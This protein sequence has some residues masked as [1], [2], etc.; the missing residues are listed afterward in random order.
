MTFGYSRDD[1]EG[2]FLTH[3]VESNLLPDNPFQVLDRDGV[4]RLIEWAVE[5]GK[6]VKPQLKTSICGEHG[7]DKQ[8]IFFC[9][10]VGLDYVSCS[11][12][13][14]P[15]ARIAAA[16]AQLALGKAQKNEETGLIPER[17]A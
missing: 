10:A 14:V 8:S 9:H 13:R 5:Q 16:Q 12:Y 1:A 6:S 11:P 17:S 15:L 2:K 7:G 4:G 3:Y